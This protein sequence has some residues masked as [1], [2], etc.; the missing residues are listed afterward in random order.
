MGITRLMN[1]LREKAPNAIKT[2]SLHTYT[3]HAFALDASMAMYQFLIS[4]QQIKSGF[5][6]AE[7]R[8]SNGNLTGH[9]LGLYNRSIMLMENGI[10]PVWV[11][12]GKPP[13]AKSHVLKQRK[14]RK[15]DAEKGKSE[16]KDEGD[17]ERALKLSNQ[18]VK[19]DQQMTND[20]KRLVQLLGLPM[21][22]APSE[23]EATCSILAKSGK[24]Y[25]AAT[26]DMDSLC[27]GCPIL[28]RDINNKNEPVI[29]INLEQ[30]LNELKINM[31][32]F[33]DLCILCGCDYS[34]KI[35]GIGVINAYKLIKEHKNIEGVIKYAENFNKDPNHKKKLTY[36]KEEFNYIEAREL[37]KHPEVIDVEKV[38]LVWKNPDKEGLKK[39]LVDEKNFNENRINNALVRI[40][41]AKSKSSQM[42]M[43]NFFKMSQTVHSSSG[44]KGKTKNESNIK[45]KAKGKG[46]K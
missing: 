44:V 4:T 14:Q 43:E 20:A 31:D 19:I 37:F 42:R 36:D 15:E 5:S 30:V 2:V 32:E 18:T 23:A 33:I 25:A 8:D 45:A 6:I 29:E 28:I 9:L 46:K 41:N 12:D 11:F 10:K 16:A 35:E 39:F 26:E 27:F 7:L 21:I 24:V 40:E 3:G 22:E 1:L 34:S 13:E 17:M 38:N